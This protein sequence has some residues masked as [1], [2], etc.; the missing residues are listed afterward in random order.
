[1]TWIPTGRLIVSEQGKLVVDLP[2]GGVAFW[3]A[4]GKRLALRL[5]KRLGAP[6]TAHRAL[7]LTLYPAALMTG[8]LVLGEGGP[9]QFSTE[10]ALFVDAM[11]KWWLA[12]PEL[13]AQLPEETFKAVDAAAAAVAD[14]P[15]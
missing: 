2:G 15:S 11:A 4:I 7:V 10:R 3:E 12:N 8:Q 13:L 5:G 1:M 6:L 14:E 9:D